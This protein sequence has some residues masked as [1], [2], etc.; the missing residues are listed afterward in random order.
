MHAQLT[1]GL[2]LVAIVFLKNSADK[3]FFEF[4]YRFAIKNSAFMHLLNKS[5]ELVLHLSASFLKC[6][7]N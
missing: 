6:Y 5:F 4:T 7:E 3:S 1:G 2:A